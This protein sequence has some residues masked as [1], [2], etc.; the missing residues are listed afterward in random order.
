[1]KVKLLRK[2]YRDDYFPTRSI[3]IHLTHLFSH[4]IEQ[5]IKNILGNSFAL[6]I[7]YFPIGFIEINDYNVFLCNA[8]VGIKMIICMFYSNY[9]Q[10]SRGKNEKDEVISKMTNGKLACH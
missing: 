3:G 7:R 2:T 1:M 6:W 9:V 4:H 5:K 8:F 10:V